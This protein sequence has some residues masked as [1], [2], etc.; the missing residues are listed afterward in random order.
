MVQGHAGSNNPI[1][2]IGSIAKLE[3]ERGGGFQLEL[4]RGAACPET[5]RSTGS[6][7]L[8]WVVPESQLRLLPFGLREGVLLLT[9]R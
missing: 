1:N 2:G 5:A 7:A 8:P 6:P 3:R 9:D 4:I